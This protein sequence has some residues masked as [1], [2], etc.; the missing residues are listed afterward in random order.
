MGVTPRRGAATI[1]NVGQ[2]CN[3]GRS[4]ATPEP[5]HARL[6]HFTLNILHFAV[7]NPARAMPRSSPPSGEVP[8]GWRGS[9]YIK[10]STIKE[11]RAPFTAG[12]LQFTRGFTPRRGAATVRNVIPPS[13]NTMQLYATPTFTLSLLHFTFCGLPGV[14]ATTRRSDGTQRHTAQH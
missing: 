9:F 5:R 2:S 12:I 4:R 6:L 11:S 8:A 13:T 7:H 3:V 14:H 1:R 10:Y